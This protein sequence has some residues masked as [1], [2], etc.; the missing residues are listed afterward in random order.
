MKKLIAM[1]L[2]AAPFFMTSCNNGAPHASFSNSIDTISYELGMANSNGIDRYLMQMGIDSADVQ[3]FLQG[4][5]DGT[6]NVDDAKKKAYYAGIQIGSQIKSQMFPGIERMAF[7]NDSTKKINLKNFLSGFYAGVLND[8][9]VVLNG[10]H[11]N[12]QVAGVDV[13]VRLRKLHEETAR[14]ANAENIKAGEEFIAAK[15]EEGY[16]ELPGGTL[17]K[18]IKEGKGATGK[19]GDQVNVKYEGKLINGTV[20]DSTE[21]RNGG[22]AAEMT[23][24]RMVPGFN[25][26]L[27]AMPEGSTWEIIIPAEQA[28]GAQQAGQIAPF[29]TLIFTVEVE[30][31]NAKK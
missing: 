30:K 26:A 21:K 4:V 24:G 22:K 16:K 12:P 5:K 10:T 1:A 17:Y 25:E 9:T 7:G 15:K 19:D 31:V 14:V 8:T 18:V 23:I 20:F 6:L 28:Y 13:D 29:S 3:E 27:K 2:L 11:M